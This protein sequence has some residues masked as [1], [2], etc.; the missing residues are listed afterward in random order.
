MKIHEFVKF[1]QPIFYV[2]QFFLI[3]ICLLFVSYLFDVD[4][5]LLLKPVKPSHDKRQLIAKVVCV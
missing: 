5:A 1:F 3:C 4:S 2:Y